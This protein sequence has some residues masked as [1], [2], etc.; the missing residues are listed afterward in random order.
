VPLVD[1]GAGAEATADAED[2]GGTDGDGTGATAA[3]SPVGAGGS[4]IAGACVAATVVVGSA[5]GATGGEYTV[6]RVRDQTTM[7]APARAATQNRTTRMITPGCLLRPGTRG[8]KGGAGVQATGAG[9]GV[10][11]KRGSGAGAS[12]AATGGAGV[13]AMG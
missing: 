7:D 9:R 10:G 3:G 1:E 12:G 11:A 13:N 5:T 6:A 8:S 2:A 4:D